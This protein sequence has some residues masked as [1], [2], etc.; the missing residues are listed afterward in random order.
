MR[1]IV[2]YQTPYL[3]LFATEDI[4]AGQE[5]LYFYG[6]TDQPWY[7]FEVKLNTFLLSKIRKFLKLFYGQKLLLAET[8][9]IFLDLS[10][11]IYFCAMFQNKLSAK[12]NF[13][14]IFQ[15]F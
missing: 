3:C 13:P 8:F 1:K 15:K 9:A 2:T 4:K 7:Q 14:K 5:I 10:A 12:L 11:K 6:R